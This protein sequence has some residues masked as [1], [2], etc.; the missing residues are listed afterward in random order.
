MNILFNMSDWDIVVNGNVV[1]NWIVILIMLVPIG[2]LVWRKIIHIQKR[3]AGLPVSWMEKRNDRK[4]W[5]RKFSMIEDT[6]GSSENAY[7]PKKQSK[8]EIDLDIARLEKE[9]A[10]AKAKQEKNNTGE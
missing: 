1:A 3:K 9:L 2:L 5:D 8:E 10:E 6:L 7:I 4:S